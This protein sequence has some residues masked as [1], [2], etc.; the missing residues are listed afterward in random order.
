MIKNNI[1]LIFLLVNLIFATEL[2][3]DKHKVC[4]YNTDDMTN[5]ENN[6]CIPYNKKYYNNNTYIFIDEIKLNEVLNLK[7]RQDK[8]MFNAFKNSFNI[9]FSF[10]KKNLKNNICKYIKKHPKFSFIFLFDYYYFQK[11]LK[12]DTKECGIKHIPN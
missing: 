1:F 3:I 10:L 2:K 6:I 8:K 7:K 4:F 11:L 9:K 5:M 12:I